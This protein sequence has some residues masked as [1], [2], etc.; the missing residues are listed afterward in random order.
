MGILAL[1]R[2]ALDPGALEAVAIPNAQ[3]DTDIDQVVFSSPDFV[4]VPNSIVTINNGDKTR[5]VLIQFS[6]EAHINDW[7][8]GGPPTSFVGPDILELGY[9][10]NGFGCF[11]QSGPLRFAASYNPE[12]HTAIHVPVF[13]PGTWTIQPCIRVNNFDADGSHSGELRYRTLTAEV[14][15]K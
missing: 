11:P 3:E 5:R 7:N 1:A 15:T 14:L 10:F 13:G 12:S 6:A 9:S 2:Q 4:V 8:G